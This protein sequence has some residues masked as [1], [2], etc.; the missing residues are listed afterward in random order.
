M[1][2]IIQTIE[3]HPSLESGQKRQ[4][5]DR[6]RV[7]VELIVENEEQITAARCNANLGHC[8]GLRS[9]ADVYQGFLALLRKLAHIDASLS[10]S[11]NEQN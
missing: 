4:L 1:N 9:C 7:L 6:Q 2:E 10:I 8:G 3:D 5:T 11:S